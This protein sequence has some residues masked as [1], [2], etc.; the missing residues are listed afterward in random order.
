MVGINDIK[1][2]LLADIKNQ[3]EIKVKADQA[4]KDQDLAKSQKL[5]NAT[6]EQIDE[7]EDEKLKESMTLFTR[8]VETTAQIE[9]RLM[10]DKPELYRETIVGALMERMSDYRISPSQLDEETRKLLRAKALLDKA[11]TKIDEHLR[12]DLKEVQNQLKNFKTGTNSYLTS[13]YKSNKSE[14]EKLESQ[15]NSFLETNNQEKERIAPWKIAVPICL[16]LVATFAI[17]VAIKR[18]KKQQ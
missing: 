1:D 8:N 11:K 4:K 13:A 12:K 15:I 2:K 9:A 14:G 16:A 7:M 6:K 10:R 17:V 3:K 18:K 5:S